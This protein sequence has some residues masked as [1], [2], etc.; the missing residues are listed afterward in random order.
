MNVYFFSDYAPNTQMLEELGGSIT[1]QFEDTLSNIHRENHEIVF[2]E[3]RIIYRQ[4]IKICHTIPADSI[5][6]L[7]GSILLQDA[8]LKAGVNTL[9]IPQIKQAVGKWG[10]ILFK[11]CGLL[12]V[13]RIEVSTSEWTSTTSAVCAEKIEE[14]M[15]LAVK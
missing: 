5:V 13:H 11:Y 15:A 10:G 6:V 9:L 1:E 4:R 3:D 2:T 8:W 7:D 14:R 12:Q